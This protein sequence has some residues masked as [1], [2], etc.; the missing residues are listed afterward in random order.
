MAQTRQ[1]EHK[2]RVLN[3]LGETI[4]EATRIKFSEGK[5]GEEEKR[6]VGTDKRMILNRD[7]WRCPRCSSKVAHSETACGECEKKKPTSALSND[8]AEIENLVRQCKKSIKGGFKNVPISGLGD[9]GIREL[10]MHVGILLNELYI[11]KEEGL[12]D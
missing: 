10:L 9:L 1:T 8:R 11:V 4:W 6:Q 3:N 2:T 7:Y 5:K 12:L